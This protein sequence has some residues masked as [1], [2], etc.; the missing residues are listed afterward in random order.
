MKRVIQFLLALSVLVA[1]AALWELGHVWI[2]YSIREAFNSGGIFRTPQDFE[3]EHQI[4]LWVGYLLV[5]VCVI[6]T[7]FATY[8]RNYRTD[9]E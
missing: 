3:A 9:R 8:R 1:A 6:V 5:A 4:R 2:G 7:L